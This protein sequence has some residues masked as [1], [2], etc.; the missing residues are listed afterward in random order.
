MTPAV[1]FSHIIKLIID[2]T[3]LLRGRDN[4]LHPHTSAMFTHHVRGNLVA[5]WNSIH[6]R[7]RDA[8]NTKCLK[9]Y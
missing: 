7:M 9:N 1:D 8:S 2:T 3:F 6:C 4:L 5:F